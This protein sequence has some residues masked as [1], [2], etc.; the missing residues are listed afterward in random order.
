MLIEHAD[1][2]GLSQLHQLRGR[3]SR[4][5]FPG[6]CILM[7]VESCS[8]EA[9]QRLDIMC[10]STDGF[11]I[12]EKDLEIRGPGELIGTRQS[13]LPGFW[14]ADIVR[15]H[16]LLESAR[17]EALNQTRIH[18]DE[19]TLIDHGLKKVFLVCCQLSVVIRQ[20]ALVN[21]H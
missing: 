14:F 2:F 11:E 15:D 13:G 8:P 7:T 19:Q 16:K 5:E 1:R 18:T 12:A 20:S 3:V 10:K 6:T 9:H 4:G 21:R 17:E